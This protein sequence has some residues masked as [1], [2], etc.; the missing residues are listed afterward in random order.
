MA[1]LTTAEIGEEGRKKG[2][3]LL[4][5]GREVV[6]QLVRDLEVAAAKAEKKKA[7]E[8]AAR[9]KEAQRAAQAEADHPSPYPFVIR[10]TC[11]CVRKT[12]DSPE[13]Q[14]GSSNAKQ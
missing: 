3:Y 7:E 12:P 4:A 1:A 13:A 8:E 2:E 9:A 5:V 11:T 10:L 6:D 14:S